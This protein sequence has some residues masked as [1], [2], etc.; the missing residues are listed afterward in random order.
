MKPSPGSAALKQWGCT[1][2]SDGNPNAPGI[3]VADDSL[4]VS[5]YDADGTAQ[6]ARDYSETKSRI[7]G[8][9]CIASDVPLTVATVA[10]ELGVPGIPLESARLAMDKLAM[11]TR[12]AVDGIP[13]PWFSPVDEPTHLRDL[14]SEQGYPLVIKPVDSRGARGVLRLMP[15]VDL[16]IAFN[17][18]R[19]NSPT[20]RVMLERFMTGPQ[21]STE[22]M[23]LNGTAYTPGFS[24]RNY[25]LL[26]A[27]AP[28]IIENGGELPSRLP[29]DQQD[30]VRELVDR[31][32]AS[33]GIKNGIVKGDVV[34]TD[35]KPYII[36]LAARLSGG[37]FCTHEIPLNTGVDLVSCAIRMALREDV[38]PDE[39][40]PRYQRGVAQRY[41]FPRPGRVVSISGVD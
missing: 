28:N 3:A 1:L 37:Y 5:T 32:A 20:G 14:I 24:D 12:F 30:A 13:V 7:D 15:D 40:R 27:Y 25:E 17:E 36:E 26:D 4:I 18:A 19:R 2:S 35:G 10:A 21:I 6:A 16:D 34:V 33:M 38:Q 29:E 31:G 11:K 39:L 8:V 23:V 22:S 9:M 41:I